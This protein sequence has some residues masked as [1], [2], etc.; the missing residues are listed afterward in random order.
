MEPPTQRSRRD[1]THVGEV[2]QPDW[3]ACTAGRWRCQVASVLI[4]RKSTKHD[5]YG[6][7]DR[8]QTDRCRAVLTALYPQLYREENFQGD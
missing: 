4:T 5:L 2:G 8:S 6:L 1:A 7:G 3:R